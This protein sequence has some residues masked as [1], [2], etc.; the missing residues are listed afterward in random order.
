MINFFKILLSKFFNAFL[1]ALLQ[2]LSERIGTSAD[3]IT[4][5]VHDAENNKD[6]NGTQKAELVTGQLKTLAIT[7]GK[8][9]AV[10]DIKFAIEAAV[11]V[12]RG[13]V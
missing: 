8:D 9:A 3:T 4:A 12:I 6:L 1:W 13:G 10:S 5:L 2:K 11:K 7:R